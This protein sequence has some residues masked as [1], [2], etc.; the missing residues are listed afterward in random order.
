[1]NFGQISGFLIIL[2]QFQLYPTA[3][4]VDWIGM[5]WLFGGMLFIW[6]GDKHD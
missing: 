4:S 5:L 1:M 2:R 6:L 3:E